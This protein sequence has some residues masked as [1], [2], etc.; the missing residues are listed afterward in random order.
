MSEKNSPTIEDYLGMMFILQRD[1]EPIVG[2]RLAE[3]IGVTPPTVT[4]TLKRMARD[5]LVVL[6]DPGGPRLS[7]QGL[8]NARSVMRRHMLTEWLLVRN[9][10]VPWSR[11]H[12][13]AH[14]IEHSISPEVEAQMR[15]NLE[16]PQVCPHGNPLPGYE[17]VAKDWV[18]LRDL[19]PGEQVVVRRVH[20][21]AEDVPMLLDYLEAKG[22]LP[23]VALTVESVLPFN[24]TLSVIPQGGQAVT[25][26]FKSAQY[27][28][29]ERPANAGV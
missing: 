22:I 20:E 29:V 6:D 16:D 2:T 4:N 24:E 8:E 27:I 19:A 11:V 14:Q 7:E 21:M 3:L 1:G 12:S 9:L 15:A 17:G 18:R 10:K 28:Y 26:G 25:L 13:E 5:G 23:G